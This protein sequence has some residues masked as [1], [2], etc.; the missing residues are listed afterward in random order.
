[1]I[2]ENVQVTEPE[3]ETPNDYAVA[4]SA[5][6]AH[7]LATRPNIDDLVDA[8]V[9]DDLGR[10]VLLAKPG[11]KLIVE[12]FAT[13]LPGRPWLDTRTYTIQTIDE[14]TGRIHLWDDELQR[15]AL[16][17]Y[18]G[19]T[20]AGYRFKLPTKGR[21]LVS[22]KRKRGRPKKIV[23]VKPV[24]QS[25]VPVATNPDGTPV[26]RGRGR[27]KGIKNR[28]KETIS[29]EK[30]AKAELKAAK[31]RAKLA[32]IK[33]VKGAKKIERKEPV[34]RGVIMVAKKRKKA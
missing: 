16:T 11:E 15:T 25:A 6:E 22:N 5:K 20:T 8:V 21:A 9:R 4:L 13:I 10:L 32:K 18:I 30:K 17:D 34:S 12:R 7:R 23:A 31:K 33:M 3:V 27:P 1:M 29:A 19:G 28:D 2:D 26:K 24:E 14:A